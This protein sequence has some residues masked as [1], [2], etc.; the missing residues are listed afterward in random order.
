M[1]SKSVATKRGFTLV[2]V[3]IV[4]AIIALLASIAIQG[5]LR[6]RKRSHASHV[7][8]DLRL[9]DHALDRYAIESNKPAGNPV[10]VADWTKY[11]KVGTTLYR[12]G[13]DVLGNSYGDQTV[14][15]IPKVPT[16]SYDALSDVAPSSFWSPYY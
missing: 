2:E 10:S 8:N 15:S 16:S 6:A 9:I 12:T 4:A 5:F 13:L 7:I 14:D 11:M 1:R 3:T